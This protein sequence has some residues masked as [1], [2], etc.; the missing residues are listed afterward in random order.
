LIEAN[1]SGQL[2]RVIRAETGIDFPHRF[3][4]YDGEPFY[5]MEI[6]GEAMEVV[7]GRK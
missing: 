2:G 5:P 6:V 1:Y 4:K 7:H 3:L